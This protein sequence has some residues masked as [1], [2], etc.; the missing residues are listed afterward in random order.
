MLKNLDTFF[1]TPEAGPAAAGRAD[2][3]GAEASPADAE[4]A[5]AGTVSELPKKR[6]ASQM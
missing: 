5:A 6:S 4:G 1:A 3:E 2:A